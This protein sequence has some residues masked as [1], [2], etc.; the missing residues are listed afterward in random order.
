[1]T[2]KCFFNSIGLAILLSIPLSK[3][4]IQAWT[5]PEKQENLISVEQFQQ[6]QADAFKTMKE[7][8]SY[9]AE[10]AVKK[11]ALVYAEENRQ[12]QVLIES[13]EILANYGVVVPEDV[14]RY[15]EAAGKEF[16]ICPELLEAVAWRESRFNPKA[17]NQGC[18]GIMQISIKWHRQ[19]MSD[20]GISNIFDTEGNIRIG[21]SYLKELIE[22]YE[23]LDVVLKKYHGDTTKGVSSYVVEII[24]ISAALE[25]VHGK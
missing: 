2:A 12:E 9:E 23:D 25:R 16:G 15:C 1:M 14:Q 5:I 10:H 4:A 18:L 22:Q 20:L 3:M 24:E 19:R 6:Y 7:I 21:A 8:A 13:E 11:Q 17:E